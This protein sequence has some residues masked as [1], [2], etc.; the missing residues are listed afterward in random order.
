[1][2]S[3]VKACLVVFIFTVSLPAAENPIQKK[4]PP[5][6]QSILLGEGLMIVYSGIAVLD[7][8]I[9][10]GAMIPLSPLAAAPGPEGGAV[11]ASYAAMGSIIGLGIFNLT[12]PHQKDY[13]DKQVFA[14][15]LI[16]WHVAAGVILLTEHFF[17]GKKNQERHVYL[18]HSSDQTSLVYQR[19]F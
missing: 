7:P 11:P 17:P 9:V 3:H 19:R 13:S 15:N 18:Q 10:G 8:E 6:W 2:K 12:V 16:G 14:A 4:K 5:V 1:M